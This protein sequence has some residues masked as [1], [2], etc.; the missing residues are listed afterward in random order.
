ML[1]CRKQLRVVVC[2]LFVFLSLAVG[3]RANIVVQSVKGAGQPREAY[4]S[5]LYG[6]SYLLP[7][8][9]LMRS[10]L[11]N[12]PDVASGQRER[13]VLVTEGTSEES[14]NQLRS[15]GIT[16]NR[17]P[18]VE[19]PYSNDARFDS[20]F[21]AVMTKLTIFNLTQFERLTFIDADALVL[22]DMSDVFRCGRFCA[23][24]INPC[25]FNSGMMQLMPSTETFNEM[26]RQLPKL[27]SYDGGDQGFL[28]AFY[29]QM[30]TAPMFDP[31]KKDADMTDVDLV[32][33]PF[34]FHMDH[35][36][37]Y[38]RFRWDTATSRCGGDVREMEWLGPWFGKPWLWWTYTVLDLSWEW[39]KYRSKLENSYPPGVKNSTHA[40]AMIAACYIVFL[41]LLLLGH[42]LYH[43]ISVSLPSISPFA[44][45][46]RRLS[47]MVSLLLGTVLCIA[48]FAT[49]FLAIP[50]MV[51]PYLAFWTFVHLRA[52]LTFVILVFGV[53]SFACCGQHSTR[54]LAKVAAVPEH[55]PCSN[56]SSL[57][58]IIAECGAWAVADGLLPFVCD[59]LLWSIKFEA[60]LSRLI[61]FLAVVAL[62]SAMVFAMLTRTS[63]LWLQWATG[64]PPLPTSRVD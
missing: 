20:R 1:S 19:T 60:L 55:Q 50:H 24:F 23:A 4:V 54:V 6:N 5:L 18:M 25:H 2:A 63:I 15:D 38:P 36:A 21:S 26:L 42:H 45:V 27:P 34:S 10:L 9:V 13:L 41:P 28:N 32:R 40:Y 44:A 61:F 35:S 16:V 29:P 57:R 7:V 51:T 64:L 3:A 62:N 53:G 48:A 22:R 59:M 8:R 17:V 47:L 46:S 31:Q 58:V 52:T 56:I 39:N 37:F 30:L 49:S 14:V 12:S 11:D 33:L 43:F